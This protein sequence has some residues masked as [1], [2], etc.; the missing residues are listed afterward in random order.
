MKTKSIKILLSFLAVYFIWGST[1]LAIRVIVTDVPPFLSMGSRFLISAAI[2]FCIVL[3][4]GKPKIT[5]K[6]FWSASLVG[7][8]MFTMG[9]GVVAWAEQF[10]PSGITSVLVALLPLWFIIFDMILNKKAAPKL[11]S[12]LGIVIGFLGI[13]LL[14]G[15]K[16]QANLKH[17]AY[18]PMIIMVVSSMCWAFASLLSLKL[19]R[20]KNGFMNLCVQQF[21]GGMANIAV[22]FIRG[23]S[24]TD[25]VTDMGSHSLIAFIYLITFGSVLVLYAYNYL[26]ENVNP[27]MVAT[28]SYVNPVVAL[29]LGWILLN[30]EINI[31]IIF[32]SALILIGVI[33]I[34]KGDAT[35]KGSFRKKGLFSRKLKHSA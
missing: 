30:E 32:A 19:P 16:D 14:V 15:F 8:M 20:N 21:A 13:V 26:I 35:G 5:K 11:L 2:I 3:F 34:K 23:E 17:I 12:W 27:S 28:Y 4:K 9:V 10:V 33:F 29:F 25:L 1:Y 24:A 18:F 22:G 7:V 6:E 31:Q